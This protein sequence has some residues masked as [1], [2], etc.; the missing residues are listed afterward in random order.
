MIFLPTAWSWKEEQLRSAYYARTDQL[1]IN[2]S[3][4]RARHL[5]V[6]HSEEGISNKLPLILAH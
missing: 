5:L 4:E 1:Y 3:T 6:L 2:H